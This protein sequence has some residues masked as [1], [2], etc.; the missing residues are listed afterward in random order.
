MNFGDYGSALSVEVDKSHGVHR[1]CH[2]YDPV[3]IFPLLDG[4]I[5]LNDDV[6]SSQFV[7]QIFPS[8]QEQSVA[9][10]SK[11]FIDLDSSAKDALPLVKKFLKEQP[12]IPTVANGATGRGPAAV[13]EQF[14]S[15]WQDGFPP[16]MD[17][18]LPPREVPP[19]PQGRSSSAQPHTT[20]RSATVTIKEIVFSMAPLECELHTKATGASEKMS[21]IHKLE[22][23]TELDVV[24]NGTAGDVTYM[25][26][27]ETGAPFR[28]EVER[29]LCDRLAMPRY[30]M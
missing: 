4:D 22:V 26:D 19:A 3:E 16:S 27:K 10:N 9:K 29:V 23:R 17:T 2:M 21:L 7:N 5:D 6:I 13:T 20:M 15:M 1:Q 28:G 14:C 30:A 8:V 25:V 24:R 18:P 11:R 12:S